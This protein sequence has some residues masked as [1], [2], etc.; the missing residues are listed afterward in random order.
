MYP[1]T[2]RLRCGDQAANVP[3]SSKIVQ[4]A[5][6]LPITILLGVLGYKIVTN[7]QP[8]SNRHHS[9]RR[10][11]KPRRV[12]TVK[13]GLD[14][15]RHVSIAYI[16]QVQ[17]VRFDKAAPPG[18]PCFAGEAF[19]NVEADPTQGDTNAVQHHPLGQIEQR[20]T[21]TAAAIKNAHRGGKPVADLVDCAENQSVD[22]LKG[23]LFGLNARSPYLAVYGLSYC[24]FMNTCETTRILVVIVADLVQEPP[25]F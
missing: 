1:I 21:N 15:I 22:I 25:L 18:E 11:K 4:I 5:P 2:F 16:R 20:S 12:R 9:R 6:A 13:K 14:G 24:R 23:F 3:S 17:V 19:G 8:R 10:L 7:D